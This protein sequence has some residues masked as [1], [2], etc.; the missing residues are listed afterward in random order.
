MNRQETEFLL[1]F[2]HLYL[3]LLLPL[4]W[5]TLRVF[6]RYRE[7]RL[8][9]RVPFLDRLAQITGQTPAS[10]TGQIRAAPG[11]RLLHWAVWLLVATA[12]ARPQWLEEPLTQTLPM[13]DLLVAID[14]SGSMATEDFADASGQQLQR[15]AAV[16]SVLSEFLN[17]REDDRIGLVVFGSA[18]FVQ[19]PFTADGVLLQEMLA[20]TE[21]RMA[22]P[23]TMLGDAIGLAITLFDRSEVEERLLI[24]LTD[25]NDTGSMVPPQRAAEVARDKDILIYTIGVGDP[26]AVGEES[27]DE[28]VLENIASTTGGRYFHAA[29]GVEL[30]AIY[31]ELDKLNPRKV[32]TI[33]FRP[34]K[35]LF[36]W[37]LS[38][39]MLMTLLYYGLQPLL[40]RQVKVEVPER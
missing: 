36:H 2:T 33:S 13:R 11:Q 15:L 5:L 27:L 7:R 25:G 10:A 18:A 26:T 4:P 35:D 20:E 19:A 38:L 22:G 17:K 23:R 39:A 40:H 30:A 34:K 29:D 1:Q 28:V 24:V 6:T 16:K 8:S 9:V 3:L 14:L 31:T 12:L 21:V 37:P 32:D